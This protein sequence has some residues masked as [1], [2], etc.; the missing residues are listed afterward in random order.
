MAVK[1]Q[2]NAEIRLEIE[3]NGRQPNINQKTNQHNHVNTRISSFRVIANIAAA[4]ALADKNKCSRPTHSGGTRPEV[5]DLAAGV[6][7]TAD[8]VAR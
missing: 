5:L 6:A 3:R 1:K 7:G 8:L 2:E 4:A